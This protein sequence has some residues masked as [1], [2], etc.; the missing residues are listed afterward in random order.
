MGRERDGPIFLGIYMKPF[1]LC[2]TSIDGAKRIPLLDCSNSIKM[3]SGM[4]VLKHGEDVGCHNTNGKEELIIVLEGNACIEI[5]DKP[6]ETINTDSVFYIPPETKHN[7]VNR[8]EK[9]LRYIYIVS[10]VEN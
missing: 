9:T 2:L 6:F 4:V 7:I 1:S 5:D 3:K 8:D 10:P